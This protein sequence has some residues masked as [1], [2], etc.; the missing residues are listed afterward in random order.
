MAETPQ[1]SKQH[2]VPQEV[3]GVQF[4]LIGELTLRQFGVLAAFGLVAVLIFSS[5]LPLLIRWILSLVFALGGVAFALVPVQDQPLDQWVGT[6]IRAV[7]AP[8]RRIWEKS[9]EAPEFLTLEVPKMKTPT[10]PGVTTEE[11]RRRLKEFLAEA[12]VGEAL[13]PLDIEEQQNLNQ[14]NVMAR[15]IIPVPEAAPTPTF[16]PAVAIEA[17]SPQV[18]PK[19]GEKKTPVPAP[20]KEEEV[21]EAVAPVLPELK[22]VDVKNVRERPSLAS[23]INWAEQIYKVQ[24]G[25]TASYFAPRK[26]IRVGRRLTPIAIS[27]SLVYAPVRERTIEPTVPPPPQLPA[28]T[29]YQPEAITPPISEVLPPAGAPPVSQVESLPSA[30]VEIPPLPEPKPIEVPPVKEE[31]P[32][33]PPPPKP[34]PV[35]KAK[36][37]PKPMKPVKIGEQANL[38]F[39]IAHTPQGGALSDSL[40]V[41]KNAEGNVVRATKTNELGR[42]QVGPLSNGSYSLELPQSPYPF[43]TMK[44]ELTGEKTAELDLR[45]QGKK[46]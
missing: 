23:R 15:Q 43:A 27:G 39:G 26:N 29:S 25:E 45:P 19:L 46:Q 32:A 14:I 8:T 20:A 18:T 40:L 22:F 5:G 6:L 44:V 7:Y 11:S 38:I 31:K 12:R 30:P 33:P 24:R 21:L 34:L 1:V 10:E 35:L 17:P 2:A 37:E 36:P 16:A 9:T 13:T 28:L 4:K 41:I 42:F 3:F